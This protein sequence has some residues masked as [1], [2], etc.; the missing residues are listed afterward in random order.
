[1]GGV[2]RRNKILEILREAAVPVSASKLAEQ[3]EVTRQVIVGDVALLRASNQ[4]IIAT[5]RGYTMFVPV[6]GRYIGKIACLHSRL[7]TAKEL[8]VIISHGGE[9]LDV[10]VSHPYYGDLSGPLNLSTSEDVDRF[11]EEFN[12]GEQVLLSELTGG[13]HLHTISCKNKAQF[14]KIEKELEKLGF[15]YKD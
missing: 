3:F 7:D 4:D 5:P 13:V 10:N 6:S 12:M 1:M 11:M 15:L 14:D 8:N 9:V 2:E